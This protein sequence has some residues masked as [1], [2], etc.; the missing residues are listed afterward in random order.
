MALK[1]NLI[2]TDGNARRENASCKNHQQNDNTAGK[3]H[4]QDLRKDTVHIFTSSW[5]R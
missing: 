4:V 5:N 3:A 1:F 2:A